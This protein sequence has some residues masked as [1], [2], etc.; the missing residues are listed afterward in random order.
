M[1]LYDE[2][3]ESYNDDE[4]IAVLEAMEKEEELKS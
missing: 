1:F 2:H 3:N 4:V